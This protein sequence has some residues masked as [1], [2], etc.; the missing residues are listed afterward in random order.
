MMLF[1]WKR[2]NSKP[3]VVRWQWCKFSNSSSPKASDEFYY[4]PTA[5]ASGERDYVI[6]QD[7]AALA[8]RGAHFQQGR[9]PLSLSHSPF[10]HNSCRFPNYTLNWSLSS[11][12]AL[13]LHTMTSSRVGYH[14]DY[15]ARIRH[16]NALPAPP[17]PPKLLEISTTGLSSGAYTSASFASRLAREQPLNVEADVFLG[18]DIN[19]VGLK[20][21][22][23]NDDSGKW[24]H[25]SI[26]IAI[27]A[28]LGQQ[29]CSPRKAL[30]N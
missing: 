29:S 30:F 20:G 28:Y 25:T 22:F 13:P 11:P 2:L 26:L 19:L 17:L 9:K 18:M 21:V 5:V 7:V 6:G 3:K 27:Q 14:Q 16:S 23:E 15:I 24:E 12:P 10:T 4:G 8:T 1:G